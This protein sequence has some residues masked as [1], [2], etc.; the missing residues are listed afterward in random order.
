MLFNMPPMEQ[1]G[2]GPYRFKDRLFQRFFTPESLGH[3]VGSLE[4]DARRLLAHSSSGLRRYPQIFLYYLA[5]RRH[6]KPSMSAVASRVVNNWKPTRIIPCHG[7]V[8]EERATERWA[9]AYR[10]FVKR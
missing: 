7:D 3:K 10:W 2:P 4:W 6:G 9:E 5:T 8:I 1:H